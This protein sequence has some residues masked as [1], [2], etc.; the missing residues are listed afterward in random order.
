MALLLERAGRAVELVHVAVV[1]HQKHARHALGFRAVNVD[2]FAVADGAED[3]IAVGEVV[4]GVVGRIKGLAG[5]L[6]GAVYA[7]DRLPDDLR[8]GL[9]IGAGD[10]ACNDGCAHS[11]ILCSRA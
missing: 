9:M 3:W 7:R 10:G 11:L 8:A 2:D 4:D 6:F 5:D 1:Q